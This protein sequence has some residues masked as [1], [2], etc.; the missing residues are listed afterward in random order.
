M[1]GVASF[2]CK[3]QAQFFQRN[4]LFFASI[5]VCPKTKYGISCDTKFI[6]WS[7]LKSQKNMM[8][9]FSSLL[10]L[11]LVLLATAAELILSRPKLEP[12][13]LLQFLS[14][15]RSIQN[16]LL[17]KSCAVLAQPGSSLTAKDLAMFGHF[18]SAGMFL[19]DSSRN[20]SRVRSP[21]ADCFLVITGTKA[22]ILRC[23]LLLRYMV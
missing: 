17:P 23:L 4:I 1:V 7:D 13:P 21:A 15:T 18:E 12:L 2:I 10:C 16:A 3:K 14:Y 19:F 22:F 9:T 8:F 5:N 20:K 6:P 11:F